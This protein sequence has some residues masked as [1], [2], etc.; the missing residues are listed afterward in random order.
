MWISFSDAVSL[1]INIMVLIFLWVLMLNSESI[2][3]AVGRTECWD[4][5]SGVIYYVVKSPGNIRSHSPQPHAAEGL[6]CVWGQKRQ[7]K[8]YPRLRSVEMRAVRGQEGGGRESA[9]QG[10]GAARRRH[11]EIQKESEAIRS[12]HAAGQAKSGPKGSQATRQPG[13]AAGRSHLW[14]KAR[15]LLWRASQGERWAAGSRRPEGAI[16]VEGFRN[17]GGKRYPSVKVGSSC[18]LCW[19]NYEMPR[20]WSKKPK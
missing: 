15:E 19:S 3:K 7:P 8:G 17:S 16:H 20:S 11:P 6:P 4:T 10:L 5:H 14:P 12:L 1:K 2:Y 13:V 9:V 18:V